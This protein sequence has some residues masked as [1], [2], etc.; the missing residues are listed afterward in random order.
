[1]DAVAGGF[2]LVG[3]SLVG[4]AKTG[5]IAHVPTPYRQKNMVSGV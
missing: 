5:L 3:G 2:G 4:A 1:M